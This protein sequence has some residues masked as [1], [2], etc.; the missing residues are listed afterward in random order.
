ANSA[1]SAGSTH[2]ERLRSSHSGA[3]RPVLHALSQARLGVSNQVPGVGNTWRLILVTRARPAGFNVAA[4][5]LV[6]H[7]SLL[8]GPR[9]FRLVTRLRPMCCAFDQIDQPRQ[10]IGAVSFL[11]AMAVGAD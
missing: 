5:Y 8:F 6:I 7:A 2:R 4:P 1:Q 9:H 3:H 10:R 11:R